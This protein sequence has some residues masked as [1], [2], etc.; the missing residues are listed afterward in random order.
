MGATTTM[1]ELAAFWDQMTGEERT[2]YRVRFDDDVMEVISIAVDDNQAVVRGYQ[3]NGV[4]ADNQRDPNSRAARVLLIPLTQGIE[5]LDRDD[6]IDIDDDPG[7]PPVASVDGSTMIA[8]DRFN[9]VADQQ[10]LRGPISPDPDPLPPVRNPGPADNTTAA[11]EP[12][13]GGD[14]AY[15]PKPTSVLDT[16]V[17]QWASTAIRLPHELLDRASKEARRRGIGRNVLL[18]HLLDQGL[19]AVEGRPLV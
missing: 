11:P 17:D 14:P 15:A 18:A 6:P 12:N 5:I 10:W 9:P 4:L 16:P 1:R 7:P 3:L 19:S 8:E 13:W 2:D